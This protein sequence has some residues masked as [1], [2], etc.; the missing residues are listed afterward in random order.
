MISKMIFFKLQFGGTE[1]QGMEAGSQEWGAREI[2][3]LY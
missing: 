1:I 2:Q 3:D